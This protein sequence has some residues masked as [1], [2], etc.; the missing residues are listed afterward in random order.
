MMVGVGVVSVVVVVLV[1]RKGYSQRDGGCDVDVYIIIGLV[2]TVNVVV[3][4]VP[5]DDDDEEEEEDND[6][7]NDIDCNQHNKDAEFLE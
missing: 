3:V 6:E 1:I 5:D 4:V 7:F 2:K